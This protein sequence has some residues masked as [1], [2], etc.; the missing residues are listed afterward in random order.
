[1]S[2]TPRTDAFWDYIQFEDGS[3]T[4]RLI[5][6]EKA[7]EF[8]RQLERELNELR[9][10]GAHLYCTSCGSCGIDECCPPSKCWRTRY[11]ELVRATSEAKH[12]PSGG[13]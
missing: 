7:I 5:D 9:E 8:A 4:W 1:M 10:D 13:N 2:D 11:E 12:L 6:E 3:K